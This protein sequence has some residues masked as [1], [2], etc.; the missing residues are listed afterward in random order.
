MTRKNHLL[1]Y[2]ADISHA[3]QRLALTEPLHVDL[4]TEKN[5]E[6]DAD[7]DAMDVDQKGTEGGGED[8]DEGLYSDL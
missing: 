5:D 8:D 2:L 4:S 6:E 3:L 7:E 1:P